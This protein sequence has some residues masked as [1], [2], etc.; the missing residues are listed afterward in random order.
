[1]KFAVMTLVEQPDGKTAKEIY[2]Q[3]LD[4]AQAAEEL[5]F[6]AIWLAEHHFTEYGICASIPVLGA[7]IAMRT[8]RIRI[9]SGICVLPFHDPRRVAEDYAMLD[10]L[11]GGRLDFGMGRGYQPAEFAAMGA[12]MD[13]SRGRFEESVEIIDGLWNNESFSYHGKYWNF[14]DLALH[15]RPIQQ[16][17]P[18]WAAAVSPESFD[19][20]ADRNL[21]ILSAPQITP[22]DR[23][24]TDFNRYRERLGAAGH[25]DTGIEIPLQRV[26]YIGESEEEARTT[27]HDGY[28]WYQRM[29]AERM[30]T[31]DSSG[32]A[33]YEFYQRAQEHLE[34][35]KYEEI[36]A[37]RSVLFDTAE[38]ISAEIQ[39]LRDEIGLNYLICLINPG[40]MSNDVVIP[41]MER[42]AKDVMP[43]FID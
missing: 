25:P 26:T 24:R 37:S 3:T 27:P 17:I 21:K 5:G 20:A 39:H 34:R 23:I 32:S 7:A 4:I 40:A 9:G 18:M 16:P 22:L 31:K 38:N 42:L 28:M 41:S 1:M 15:P 13:E 30:A 33:S 36:C 12:N 6:E 11:S 19:N 35:A 29:N 43:N 10:V 14:D 8:S 2:D